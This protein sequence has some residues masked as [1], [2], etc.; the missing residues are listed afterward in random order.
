MCEL[1][2]NI[3]IG[4]LIGILIYNCNFFLKSCREGAGPMVGSIMFPTSY[5][6]ITDVL[7]KKIKVKEKG[8]TEVIQK[9]DVRVDT[10]IKSQHWLDKKKDVQEKE[11]V[12]WVVERNMENN[13]ASISDCNKK[14]K[15]LFSNYTNI[16]YL[17]KEKK[18]LTEWFNKLVAQSIEN[19][20]QSKKNANKI[21]NTTKIISAA[22][23]EAEDGLNQNEPDLR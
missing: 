16:Q 9:K 17:Q 15:I 22:F 20:K 4:L 8:N 13:D 7:H 21:A 3:L 2:I 10:D 12:D 5:K 11:N 18:Y 23:K 1:L 14:K 19:E 6:G